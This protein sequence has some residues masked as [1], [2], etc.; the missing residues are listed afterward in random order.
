MTEGKSREREEH[1]ER[2][3]E[4]GETI[5]SVLDILNARSFHSPTK[6]DLPNAR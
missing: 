2:G 6:L 1:G 3:S 4:S 5:P